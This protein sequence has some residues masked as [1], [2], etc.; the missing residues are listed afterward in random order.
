VYQRKNFAYGTV[1][2][3]PDPAASGTS[4]ILNSG[5]GARFPNTSGGTYVCVVKEASL[6]ATP[7][8]SEVVLVTTH[9]PAGD[10]FTVTRE[11]EGSSARTV[12]IGDEFYL[13]PTDGVWD[14]LDV[15]TTKGDI[16]SQSAAGTYSR[17]AVGT[18]DQVLLA[19]STAT[20]GIKWGSS[21]SVTL[22]RGEVPTGDVDS[23]N[24]DFTIA[25]TPVTD[26]LRVYL[27]GIRQ[28]ITDDYT[29]TGTTITFVTAPLTGD[30]ILVDYEIG[31]TGVN[32]LSTKGD[33]YTY[34][35]NPQRLAV[36]TNGYAVV[37]DS[38]EATGLKYVD[39]ATRTETLSN[40][41]YKLTA[42]PSSDHLVS[43]TTI[44]LVANE[45]QAFGDVC[46]INS[47]GEAQLIDA[48]A[49]A[50]MSAVVMCADAT[51][52]A[53]ATGNYLLYGIAR[54]DSWAWTVGGVIYGTVTGTSG[55]T[56]SQ[57]APT[58]T[59]DVV[60]I[61]GVATHADRMF[62]NPQLVQVEVV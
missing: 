27:N 20:S 43:G 19:D 45:N 26:T 41:T 3:P 25:D 62:F 17:L 1:L 36:G 11:Q 44:S 21:G 33:I 54:D 15:L 28:K 48:D 4:I 8:N 10:T 29:F 34:D 5:E 61:M 40:K 37:A 30:K 23:S 13:A 60:Q 50:T 38:A 56:L 57:T 55:N 31:T 58:A 12:V 2:T 14:Q 52:S 59:D 35:T 32:V 24:A 42:A 7:S 49:I 6:P 9:D 46:Y 53:D 16:L 51:I 47:S 39:L 18:N 22:V